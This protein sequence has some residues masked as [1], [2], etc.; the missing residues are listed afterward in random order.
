MTHLKKLKPFQKK[1]KKTKKTYKMTIKL[2]DLR[3]GARLLKVLDQ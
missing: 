2:M 1:E 3:V